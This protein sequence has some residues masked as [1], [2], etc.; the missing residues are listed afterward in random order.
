MK[1]KIFILLGLPG[2][3]KG[4]QGVKLSDKLAIPHISTGD[5]FRA[6]ADTDSQEAEILKDYM[7]KG[8]LIPA[9]IVN[10]TVRTY[11]LSDK[12]R[13]GC[14]LD[15][16][17]R[18]LDQAEYFIENIDADIVAILFETSDEVVTKRITGRY[19]C[20]KCGKLYNKFFQKPKVD[21]VC[22]ACGSEEFLYREDDDEET[23]KHRLEEYKKETLPLVDYYR[24]KTT[25][26]TINADNEEDEVFKELSVIVK[27]V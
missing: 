21:G 20:K 12:C 9:D 13:N 16:Y 6:I 11:I 1:K 26:F 2:S 14:I 7:S 22:D 19:S 18:S 24:N 3:G 5:I 27:K 15:G 4:T 17:P 25:L 8:K 10:K 23:I